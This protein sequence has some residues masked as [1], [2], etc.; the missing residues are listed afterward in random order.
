MTDY[1][2]QTGG[3]ETDALWEQ[4]ERLDR[5][6]LRLMGGGAAEAAEHQR[7]ERE[8]IGAETGEERLDARARQRRDFQ[9]QQ[10]EGT[11]AE[12]GDAAP[13]QA[14]RLAEEERVPM[15]DRTAEAAFPLL[16]RLEELDRAMRR[17]G[18]AAGWGNDWTRGT[19][20]ARSGG[21]GSSDPVG[22]ARSAR[23]M[24]EEAAQGGRSGGAEPVS[25]L[26]VRSGGWEEIR[27]AEQADR[28][29]RRDSRRYDGGFYLY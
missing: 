15:A 18:S 9:A 2:E 16:D 11:A 20:S 8:R 19:G 5:V 23:R 7:T 24:E 6:L 27:W 1:L 10:A 12:T 17:T 3:E 14:G 25:Q 13:R 26:P 22:A 4:L 21:R 29:F 28:V